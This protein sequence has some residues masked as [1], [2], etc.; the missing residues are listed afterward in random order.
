MH[1]DL[2]EVEKLDRLML[3]L[4]AEHRA[5]RDDM[6]HHAGWKEKDAATVKTRA[7]FMQSIGEV[8]AAMMPEPI[9]NAKELSDLYFRKPVGIDDIDAAIMATTLPCDKSNS[10]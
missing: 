2:N 1:T 9:S 6:I 3:K 5:Y 7:G 4:N 10:N 8:L